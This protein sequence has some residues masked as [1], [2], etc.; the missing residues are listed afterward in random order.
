MR[1]CLYFGSVLMCQLDSRNKYL[2][3]CFG[4]VSACANF[5]TI[6]HSQFQRSAPCF[7][8]LDGFHSEACD[9][10]A[11]E[12]VVSRCKLCQ[13]SLPSHD[14]MDCVLKQ[15]VNCRS[16]T[17]ANQVN[18]L[19]RKMALEAIQRYTDKDDHGVHHLE[20]YMDKHQS[21]PLVIT[22]R[23]VASFSLTASKALPVFYPLRRNSNAIWL[24]S[25]PEAKSK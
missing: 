25:I 17:P 1:W 6:S 12:K 10:Q 24:D 5:P 19:D 3:A 18:R 11:N 13:T 9:N 7:S 21:F 22:R 15:S 4:R 2:Q 23:L 20:T 14:A 16:L 8:D